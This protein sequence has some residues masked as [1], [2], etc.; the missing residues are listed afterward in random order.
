MNDKGGIFL[1]TAISFLCVC[2]IISGSLYVTGSNKATFSEPSINE[3]N[4]SMPQSSTDSSSSAVSVAAK[5]DAVGKVI[6]QFISPYKS[7]T[8]YN[9]VYIKNRAKIDLNIEKYLNAPSPFKI[10]KNAEP[11]ILIMHTHTTESYM[12]TDSDVYTESFTSRSTDNSKNM[13]KIG[14]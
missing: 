1:L 7:K 12:L 5:A 9:R 13:V 2:L 8:Y 3:Y 14:A 11:Q 6:P 10:K 4:I